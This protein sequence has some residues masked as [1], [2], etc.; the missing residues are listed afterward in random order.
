MTGFAV[1]LYVFT[2][3]KKNWYD[4]RISVDAIFRSHSFGPSLT[5]SPPRLA[6]MMPMNKKQNIIIETSHFCTLYIFVLLFFFSAVLSE[7]ID[8]WNEWD[9]WGGGRVKVTWGIMGKMT[10][11]VWENMEIWIILL[12]RRCLFREIRNSWHH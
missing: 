3:I 5:D 12:I 7:R 6:W 1:L 4:Y 8:A 11:G 10:T 9:I 2:Q